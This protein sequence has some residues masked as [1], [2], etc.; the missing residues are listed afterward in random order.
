VPNI[1]LVPVPLYQPN[2][3][4]NSE[5]D[6]LPIRGL[7]DRILL[8]NSQVDIDATILSYAQGT[9]GSLSNRLSQSI[10][11]DGTLKT[12]AIDAAQHNIAEHTDGS[13]IVNGTPIS[14]VRMLLDERAKLA[15]VA[16]GA[17]NLEILVTLNNP[18]PSGL[19]SQIS[20]IGISEIEY[21]SGVMQLKPSDSIYWAVDSDGSLTANTNFPSTVRHLHNYDIVPVPQNLLSP[22]YKNYIV[23]S[24]ATQYRSGSLRVYINGIRL[25]KSSNVTPGKAPRGNYVPTGFDVGSPIWLTYTYT[26]DTASL[27][28][29]VITSGK[30][31][32]S[33]SITENDVITVDFDM[34]Y[35]E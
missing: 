20:M 10:N 30:F 6:N 26:E 32:L 27:D 34:L 16:P 7:I 9:Q 31:S 15:W 17:T 33:N 5:I 11:A 1:D 3:P 18:T 12:S 24:T 4:Y 35:T 25:T 8:V 21:T 2:N 14:Y 19:P 23:T 22:D 29:G 13:I 28:D